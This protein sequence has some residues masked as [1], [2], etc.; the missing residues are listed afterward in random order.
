M[1]IGNVKGIVKLRQSV[2]VDMTSKPQLK[3][4]EDWS[5]N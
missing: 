3:S 2:N 4:S 5:S 1:F